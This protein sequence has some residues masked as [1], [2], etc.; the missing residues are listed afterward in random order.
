MKNIIKQLTAIQFALLFAV[1]LG[2]KAQAGIVYTNNYGSIAGSPATG[3]MTLPNGQN[4]TYYN[5]VRL[6]NPPATTFWL[7]EHSPSTTATFTN[8][9]SDGHK[10]FWVVLRKSDSFSWYG[11]NSVSFNTTSNAQYTY[12][13][14]DMTS[15]GVPANTL[16]SAYT[17]WYN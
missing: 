7:P 13:G 16:I 8:D 12:V 1:C 14:Y 6:T 11:T 5:V 17:Y 9:L 10:W 3:S 15:P 4:L 2:F